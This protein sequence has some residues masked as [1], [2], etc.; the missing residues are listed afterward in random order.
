[1]IKRFRVLGFR[2]SSPSLKGGFR[3]LGAKDF[4]VF[5]VSDSRVKGFRSLR[6]LGFRISGLG[7]LGVYGG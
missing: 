4:K 2:S 7:A 1:M 6:G 5:K 3:S